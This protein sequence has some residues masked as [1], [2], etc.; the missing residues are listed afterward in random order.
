M[1][2]LAPLS[3]LA[4]LLA[5]SL[6]GAAS[7]APAAACHCFTE[8]AYVPERPA[9][10]D[11]YILATTRSSLLSAAFGPSKATL[12]RTV[13]GGADPDDLWVAH[14][15]AARLSRE[16]GALLDARDAGGSWQ[17][18]L[19][20]APRD[21]LGTAFAARLDR[22]EPARGLAAAV[23]DE[24]LVAR[25]GAPAGA[26]AALR[27]GGASNAEVILASLLAARLGAPAPA[28][29]EAVRSGRA[30]WGS[31]LHGAGIAPAALDGLVRAAVR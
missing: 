8:R 13:M 17:K 23:V 21:R 14:F 15:A 9:A 12:V 29:L 11:P 16:A 3:L 1:R 27:V 7:A 5:A 28:L 4:L 31:T 6:P 26:L 22:G 30:T 25:T 10:A 20:G 24:V 19:A 2:R 18:A